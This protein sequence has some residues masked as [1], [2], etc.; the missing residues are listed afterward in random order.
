MTGKTAD[1]PA[2]TAKRT[3]VARQAQVSAGFTQEERAAMKERAR[4]AK[5]ETRRNPRA[6]RVD[7]EGEVLTKLA[8]MP[9]PDRALGERLHTL[10]TVTAPVLSPKLWYG[11]PAYAREGKV[12]CF[13]QGARKF[14]TRY[15]TLGFSDEARLDD[16]VLWPTAFALM[17]WT[18]EVEAR[19]AALVKKAVG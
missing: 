3:A 17:E 8:E 1:Q 5:G 16:G 15:A 9:E 7:A 10:I 13:F 4:E 2:R 12:V 14:K 19:I 6:A 11:M 18:P